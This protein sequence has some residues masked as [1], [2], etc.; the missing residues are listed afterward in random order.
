MQH[1]FKFR[2]STKYLLLTL[3]L[4]I[5]EV[6]IA[7]IWKDIFWLRAYIG[8]VIVVI[9]LYTMIKIFCDIEK[10]K[11]ILAIFVFSIVVEVLQYFKFADFLGL[12][13]GSIPYILLGNSFSWIDIFCYFLGCLITWVTPKL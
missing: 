6:L 13:A 2:F 5:L 7:T 3:L 4:F 1:S 11:L 10:T 8:D 9:L 12:Q